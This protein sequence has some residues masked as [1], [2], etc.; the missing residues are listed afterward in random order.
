MKNI[1][2]SSKN[3]KIKYLSKLYNSRKRKKESKYIL[4]GENIVLE[5]M[6]SNAK[7]DSIYMTPEFN[8]SIA[9][10]KIKEKLSDNTNIYIIEENIFNELADTVNPQ[11]IIA[12]VDEPVYDKNLFLKKK[13]RILVLDRVQDPGNMGTLIRTALAADFDGIISLKGSVDIFNLKVLRS[14]MGAIFNIPIIY[15]VSLEELKELL[16][17]S[18][19]K[20][21]ST[22]LNAKK[23]YY[24]LNYN[25][26][27]LLVIGNEARGVSYK[28]NEMAD[29]AIKIP[30][31]GNIESLNAAISGGIL[32]YHIILQDNIG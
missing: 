23:Y 18:S 9:A 16:N 8:K 27:L 30:L 1:I 3:D 15:N 12:I 5:A 29:I 19:Y 26:P 28:L 14:T 13:K 21:I 6:N 22:D 20:I 4:E 32:M 2:S 17:D 31:P 25:F 7:F 11:G 24:Q 10:N